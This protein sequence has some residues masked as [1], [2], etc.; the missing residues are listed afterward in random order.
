MN[1]DEA[2][3]LAGQRT[4]LV[5]E[6]LSDLW[7]FARE[8]SELKGCIVE[9]GVWKGGSAQVMMKAA[10]TERPFYL[11]DTFEGMTPP[12]QEHDDTGTVKLYEKITS[13]QYARPY[14]RWHKT[15]KWA[16][17]P[18][19]DVVAYIQTSCPQKRVDQVHYIVGDVTQTLQR[20]Q[21]VPPG[22]I[23]LLHLDTDFYESTREELKVLA[24]KIVPG[25]YLV[26]DDYYSFAGSRAA[27]D[28]FLQTPLGQEF[29]HVPDSSRAHLSL[30]RPEE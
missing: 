16:Y 18:L 2:V 21:C 12:N 11:Y 6:A 5:P 9:C 14:D 23:V 19:N 24:P 26:V 28:R 25:G 8:T 7:W 29:K 15:N 20:T 30:Q 22:E 27:T 13:G 17:C 3:S 4:M 10:P 1:V